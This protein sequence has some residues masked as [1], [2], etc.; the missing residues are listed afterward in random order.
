MCIECGCEVSAKDEQREDRGD[1]KT[2][3]DETKTGDTEA[4]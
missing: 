2:T 3:V 1:S 4:A